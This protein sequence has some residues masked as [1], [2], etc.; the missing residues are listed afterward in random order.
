M[1]D[2]KEPEFEEFVFDGAT[3]KCRDAT[4]ALTIA[5]TGRGDKDT[6]LAGKEFL[7]IVRKFRPSSRARLLLRYKVQ[8]LFGIWSHAVPAD[9]APAPDAGAPQK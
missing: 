8:E 7:K 1:E 2:P 5:P 9:A 3:V 4:L 6:E